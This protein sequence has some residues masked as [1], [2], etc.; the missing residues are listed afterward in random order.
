[1]T[2]EPPAVPDPP[3]GPPALSPYAFAQGIVPIPEATSEFDAFTPYHLRTA[4]T[5]NPPAGAPDPAGIKPT[6]YSGRRRRGGHPVEDAAWF[7]SD[8]PARG[9]RHRPELPR[10]DEPFAQN[11]PR[12]DGPHR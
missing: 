8:A 6:G 5:P 2:P 3:Q 4:R 11:A 7:T 10:G 12:R 1:M 9:R